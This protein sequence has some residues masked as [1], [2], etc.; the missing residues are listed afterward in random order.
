[1]QRLCPLASLLLL[2]AGTIW[3]PA[4]K[5][6]GSPQ[7]PFSIS[8]EEAARILAH[9]FGSSSS[10]YGLTG[11]C[12]DLAAVAQGGSFGSLSRSGGAAL[13]T[14]TIS[15]TQ[16]AVFSYGWLCRYHYGFSG[17]AFAAEY[18]IRGT[19]DTPWLA[20]S[21]TVYATVQFTGIQADTL[22]ISGS[23]W[24]LGQ[25][26]TRNTTPKAF[27][28]EIVTTFDRLCVERPTGKLV[29]GSV[30]FT[31]IERFPDRSV[32]SLPGTFTYRPHHAGTLALNG[33]FYSVDL[34]S[35]AVFA[36]SQTGL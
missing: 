9:A 3:M 21:D 31:L 8:E 32:V 36:S 29:S 27:S 22:V 16:S 28:S 2:I 10:T 1:L 30:T 35:A 6:D 4:C 34:D 12:E 15:R 11:Q 19:Y 13:D 24:R 17:G 20:S 18:G 33:R 7:S 23:C 26:S 25:Q 5:E 14:L